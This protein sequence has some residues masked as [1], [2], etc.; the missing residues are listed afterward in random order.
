MLKLLSI[1]GVV[2][3]GVVSVTSIPMDMESRETVTT[4]RP[5]ATT[6]DTTG[7]LLSLPV[8]E[9]CANSKLFFITIHPVLCD[10][11]CVVELKLE[12]V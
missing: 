7:R 6:E 8:P 1:C 5:E 3:L 10:A 11:S 2:A 9:K 4:I 12:E